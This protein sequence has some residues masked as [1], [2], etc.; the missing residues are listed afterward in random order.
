MMWCPEGDY[1][2]IKW[3]WS[4]T[5]MLCRK[6]FA[7]LPFI[8]LTLFNLA[9]LL[10]FLIYPHL[11]VNPS[12]KLIYST[13][14]FLLSLFHTLTSF[15]GSLNLAAGF[16]SHIHSRCIIHNHFIHLLYGLYYNVH[17]QCLGISL[18]QPTM[19]GFCRHYKSPH[20]FHWI[21]SLLV[22]NLSLYLTFI[23][24]SCEAIIIIIVIIIIVIFFIVIVI[25]III[26]I[27]ACPIG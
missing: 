7:N 22:H 9:L 18:H 12:L 15:S 2:A 4:K 21:T 11:N 24:C 27:I 14:H 10:P 17:M 20:S 6:N 5:Q 3:A 23:S 8:F 25:I 26:I 1:S 19:V 13:N 16:P